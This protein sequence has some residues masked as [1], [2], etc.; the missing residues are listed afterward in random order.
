[1]DLIR[2]SAEATLMGVA[3]LMADRSTCSRAHVGAVIATH[4][5]I[6]SSGYN[7]TPAGLPHCDHTCNCDGV[8]VHNLACN[9]VKPC[10]QAVHAEANA[11]A[12]AAR[13]GVSTAGGHMFVTLS[14]C[15]P[16]AQLIISA[17]IT[18]LSYI[19]AYRDFSGM[20]LLTGA[21]IRYYRAPD[22]A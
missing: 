2:P 8:P 17:G 14:P 12:W 5:R 10:P 21:G 6:V 4:G 15:M 22:R 1:M 13:M 19:E 7:G 11:I 9:A 3:K 16:C 18:Q 20:S